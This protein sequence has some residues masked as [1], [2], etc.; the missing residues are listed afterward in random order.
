MIKST[1]GVATAKMT[2]DTQ[3]CR[4]TQRIVTSMYRPI[5]S[6]KRRRSNNRDTAIV[7]AKKINHDMS[8]PGAI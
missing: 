1:I 8:A 2:V 6:A 5:A 3:L 4:A 7:L